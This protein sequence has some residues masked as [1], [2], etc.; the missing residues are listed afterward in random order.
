MLVQPFSVMQMVNPVAA[1]LRL[2]ASMKIHPTF[3]ISWVRPVVES[4]LP[5][6]ADHPPPVRIVDGTPVYTIQKTFDVC[7]K[8][9][10]LQ[11]LVDWE[12]YRPEER[13]WV[14][15]I[16]QNFYRDHPNKPGGG[17]GGAH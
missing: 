5:P 12:G 16:L 3:H 10:G 11:Y 1:R 17:P 7:W 14:L 2:P 13:L 4:D 15:D 9:R 8:S 6:P